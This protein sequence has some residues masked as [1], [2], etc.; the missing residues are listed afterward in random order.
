MNSSNMLKLL[1]YLV[2]PSISRNLS[3]TSRQFGFRDNT[4]CQ[5]A[6]LTVKEVIY[7]YTREN[8]NVDCSLIDLTKTFDQMNFDVLISNLQKTQNPPLIT[9]LLS[10]MFN[11]S[12]LNV[13]FNGVIGNE[14]KIGNG[15][16]QV[17]ILSPFFF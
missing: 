1:E 14:W 2:L 16:R 4:N 5:T 7:S 3:V 10:F 11:N 8:S 9:K 13:Y 12:F 15:A 17:G 6:I